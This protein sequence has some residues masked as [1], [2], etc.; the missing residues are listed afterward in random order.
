MS[1]VKRKKN[2]DELPLDDDAWVTVYQ[3]AAA[4]A[5]V[6]ADMHL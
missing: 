4:S 1:Q 2:G 6:R 5:E 3:D